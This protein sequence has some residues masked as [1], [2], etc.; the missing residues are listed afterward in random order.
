MIPKEL[1]YRETHEWVRRDEDADI[2]TIGITAFAIEQLGDIVFIELPGLGHQTEKGASLGVIESV[3]DASD[4]YAPVA[5][6]VVAV[7][8]ELPDN[9]EWFK[10]DPYGQ[11]WIVKIKASDVNELDNLMDA[12]AYEKQLL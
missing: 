1:K 11:G 12:S 5:G 3:K 6:E 10:T 7:N 8:D 4:L 2:V 9:P